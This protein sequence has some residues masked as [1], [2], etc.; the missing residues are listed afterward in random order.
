[1][2]RIRTKRRR[3]LLA[4]LA[5]LIPVTGNALEQAFPSPQPSLL[6]PSGLAR[7]FSA[8]GGPAGSFRVQLLGEFFQAA[9]FLAKD[10]YDTHR[11]WGARLASSYSPV[12]WLEI[13]AMTQA[14][15]H[16]NS[17][18]PSRL[19]TYGDVTVGLKGCARLA[20]F[21]CL[22]AEGALLFLQSEEA[23][24]FEGRAT[25]SLLRLLATADLRRVAHLAPLRIHLN[26]GAILDNSD[27]LLRPH[28]GAIERQGFRIGQAHRLAVGVGL[29]APLSAQV[30]PFLEWS[31]EVPVGAVPGGS[32]DPG[33]S[34]Y[35]QILT[36][37]ARLFPWGSLGFLVAL[38]LGLTSRGRVGIPAVPP[39]QILLGAGWSYGTVTA[40][41]PKKEKDDW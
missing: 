22:G 6:G 30:T 21:L 10:P 40:S 32:R 3:G 1:M 2:V 29:E 17:R 5:G 25:S 16:E 19:S 28:Y 35:P 14:S 38:D 18:I 39:W 8:D 36:A 11:H 7:V 34:A 4:A 23:T 41:L 33:F 27:A 15:T 26:V 12:S 9:R 37:G 20:G 31:L 24:G 13:F